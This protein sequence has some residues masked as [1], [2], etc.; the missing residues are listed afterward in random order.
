MINVV[1]VLR[2]IVY[3]ERNNMG[4]IGVDGVM[5]LKVTLRDALYTTFGWNYVA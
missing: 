2:V 4:D 3:I 5:I 1:N